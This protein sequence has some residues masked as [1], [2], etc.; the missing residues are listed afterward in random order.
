MRGATVTLAALLASP[1]LPA[2][3]R[4]GPEVPFVDGV[5]R[6]VFQPA[7][8]RYLNDHTLARG[9]DGRW[10]VYGITDAS[11]GDPE[12][13][14]SFLHASAPGLLGPWREHGDAL[15]AQGDERAL[16]AP[17]VYA[18]APDRW[19]MW[20]YPNAR[21]RQ[22]HRADSDDLDAW[23]RRPEAA[24]GGRDPTALRVGSTVFLYSVGVSA[25]RRGQILVTRS[26]DLATWTE[27]VVALEDP[28]P[29]FG[30]GN[31][32]SPAVIV[33]GGRYYL[34]VTRTSDANVDYARTLVF[35]SRDPARFAWE[36]LTELIAHAAEVFEHDGVTWIT[37]A[38]WTHQVG[39]R[40]RGLAVARLAWARRAP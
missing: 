8:T 7:G 40:W 30:W 24:P 32:E 10:H 11:P 9:P 6:R 13:E 39:E 2:Q 35:A 22:I 18:R 3:P 19:T 37:S 4:D 34:F 14:R 5:F 12:A 25:E 26:V 16:W 29:S 28:E 1:T 31:L 38:G 15:T 36:P 33:R 27:P 17:F 21:D 20:F 23:T